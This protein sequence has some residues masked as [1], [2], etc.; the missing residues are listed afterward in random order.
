MTAAMRCV[1]FIPLT[2]VTCLVACAVRT[3]LR[4]EVRVALAAPVALLA[5]RPVGRGHRRSVTSPDRTRYSPQTVPDSARYELD[6]APSIGGEWREND[7]QAQ[8]AHKIA[9]D[10]APW[11]IRH[12]IEVQAVAKKIVIA[13][14][15][16]QRRIAP[17]PEPEAE[18]RVSHAVFHDCIA[19]SEGPV[20]VR[21]APQDPLP[22]HLIH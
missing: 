16:V 11:S 3:G 19:N 13:L 22:V 5:S 9:R 18:S 8:K 15:I 12:S 14:R 20:T 7:R 2:P 21:L 6:S 10:P 4:I 1:G 17:A